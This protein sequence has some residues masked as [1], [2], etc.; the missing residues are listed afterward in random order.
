MR[1]ANRFEHVAAGSGTREDHAGVV[2]AF[3]RGPIMHAPLALIIGRVKTTDVG[4]LRPVDS[5][6]AKVLEHGLNEIQAK[7]DCIQIIITQNQHALGV[8]RAF[9]GDPEGTGM[10]QMKVAC[11]R[12]RKTPAIPGIRHGEGGGERSL[13]SRLRKSIWL[14]RLSAQSSGCMT[15]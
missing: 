6:P 7:A 12:W 10:A 8:S 2:K 13:K 4:A 15:K 11:G 1:G 14:R 5:Q 3:E 9:S